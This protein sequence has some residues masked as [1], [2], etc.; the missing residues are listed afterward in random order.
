MKKACL[1]LLLVGGSAFANSA[2]A[3]VRFGI[4]LPFPFLVWSGGGDDHHR[5]HYRNDR[6]NGSAYPRPNYYF[7]ENYHRHSYSDDGHYSTYPGN[8]HRGYYDSRR[9]R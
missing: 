7:D 6:Y 9:D 8:P 4:P 1:L 3:Q 5:Q 2:Q